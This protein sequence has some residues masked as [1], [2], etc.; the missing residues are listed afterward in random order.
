MVALSNAVFTR[1]YKTPFDALNEYLT[2]AVANIMT[3]ISLAG[4]NQVVLNLIR[5]ITVPARNAL[6]LKARDD[7][8]I[9]LFITPPISPGGAITLES[10]PTINPNN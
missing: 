3:S 7:Y 6:I 10:G 2:R 5:P 8:G 9:K 1:D 4:D